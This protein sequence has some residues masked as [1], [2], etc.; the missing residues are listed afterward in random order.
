[1]AGNTMSKLNIIGIFFIVIFVGAAY[2]LISKDD[3]CTDKIRGFEQSASSAVEGARQSFSKIS[4]TVK[5]EE[6]YKTAQIFENLTPADFSVLRACDIQCALLTRCLKFV[7]FSPPSE[8]CPREYEDFQAQSKAASE[9]L[10]KLEQ[11]RSAASQLA[12]EADQIDS[13]RSGIAE[14][15]KSSGSTGGRV[16]VLKNELATKEENL[17][18]SAEYIASTLKATLGGG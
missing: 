6:I 14:I 7:F 8:A 11:T 13:L 18:A 2:F 10:A 5:S 16:A 1:M 9:L 15:E 12:K 3:I 4:A 17:I